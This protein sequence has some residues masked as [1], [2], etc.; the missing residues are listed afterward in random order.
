MKRFAFAFVLAAACG[1]S[2]SNPD[3]PASI[4]AKVSSVKSV[5]CNGAT[6]AQ[7]IN[8]NAGGTAF[9]PNTATINANQIV[10]FMTSSFHPVKSGTPASPTTDFE[11]S[12]GDACFQFTQAGTFPFFCEVHLFTGTITVQ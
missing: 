1:G 4:D 3:A 12:S 8:V 5:S 9:M 10:H 6:I 11:A 7:T 2:S